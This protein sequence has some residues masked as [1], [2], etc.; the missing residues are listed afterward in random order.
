MSIQ[1]TV[2]GF[3][4]TTTPA[5]KSFS[6]YLERKL[7]IFTAPNVETGVVRSEPLEELLVDREETAG[8]GR[9]VNGLGRVTVTLTLAFR[10][11]VPVELQKGDQNI[12]RGVRQ[13][14][15][16]RMFFAIVSSFCFK[17]I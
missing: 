6:F 14:S 8:H 10:Y 16:R 17:M 1:Y 12:S 9:A 7:K 13:G 5:Q 15:K 3:E 4:P 11:S 2:P